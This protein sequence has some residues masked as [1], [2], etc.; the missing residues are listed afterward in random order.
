MDIKNS[1]TTPYEELPYK[2]D[3]SL[4]DSIIEETVKPKKRNPI[5]NVHWFY[6]NYLINKEIPKHWFLR[7]IEKLERE[8][9]L[10]QQEIQ[11]S[12]SRDSV[13]NNFKRRIMLRP[14]FE[15]LPAIYYFSEDALPI[16]SK[17]NFKTEQYI[18]WEDNKGNQL[19]EEEYKKL[20]N[21][22]TEVAMRKVKNQCRPGCACSCDWCDID[23]CSE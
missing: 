21:Y 15:K 5:Q 7:D 20:L 14:V 23:R 9:R 10:W 12:F 19:S 17:S 1:Y 13:L 16:P 4:L 8:K 3:N 6:G 2:N 22:D 11:A 18:I